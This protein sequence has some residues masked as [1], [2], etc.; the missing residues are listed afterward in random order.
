M[1]HGDFDIESLAAFLHLTP[2]QVTR[3]AERGRIPGRKVA[4]RWRFSRPEIHEWFERRIGLSDEEE[5]LQMEDV[6]RRSAGGKELAEV[7]IADL[8]PLRAVAVP[9]FAR[10][11]NSVIEAMTELAARTG[12]L[13][14]ARSMAEAI[15]AREEMHPTAL[16]NG[17][18]LL[19][20]RRPMASILARPFLAL[21]C[22]SGGI[23]FGGSTLTDV[24]FL[25]CSTD[26]RLHL[27][28]LA[29]LSR[30]LSVPGFLNALHQAP[31]AAAAHAAVVEHE[32]SL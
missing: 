15:R 31:D 24:F 27:R 9:L 11:R 21:G 2:Q 20:P 13:W 14:D 3:L 29:R 4:G 12:W 10:T 18:A 19:H 7:C 25:V 6:L 1:H 22:T 17:V 28:V 23:P 26:E 8:L 30:L 5:L 16:D 32:A